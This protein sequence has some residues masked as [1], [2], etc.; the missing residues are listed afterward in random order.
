MTLPNP[1]SQPTSVADRTSQVATTRARA[2][3]TSIRGWRAPPASIRSGFRERPVEQPDPVAP[4]DVL[5]VLLRAAAGAEDVADLV[6][7]DD[8]VDPVGR[9]FPSALPVGVAADSGMQRVARESVRVLD[10]VDV[11]VERDVG[12]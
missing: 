4:H 3:A 5:D 9:A 7:F 11:H 2:S 1:Q 6:V 12:T 8:R 10:V